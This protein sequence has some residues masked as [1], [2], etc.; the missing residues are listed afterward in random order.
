MKLKRKPLNILS[1]LLL[2]LT[3]FITPTSASASTSPVDG[4]TGHITGPA[5]THIIAPGSS[6]EQT[7]NC[8]RELADARATSGE[9]C[10]P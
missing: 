4:L 8:L 1:A 7:F 5:S 2:A 10:W 9:A 6:F 3:L